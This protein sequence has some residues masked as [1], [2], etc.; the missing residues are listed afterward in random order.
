MGVIAGESPVPETYFGP[1]E[2][3]PWWDPSRARNAVFLDRDLRGDEVLAAAGLDWTVSKRPQ[4]FGD[5]PGAMNMPRLDGVEPILLNPQ[6]SGRW[7]ANVRD[8]DNAFLGPVMPGFRVFQNDELRA[9]GDE[10]LG[11]GGAY[12]HT[13]GSL[14]DGKIVW[15]LA[16]FDKAIHVKGDGSPIEDYLALINGHDGRHGCTAAS[17]MTR[18]WCGNTCEQALKGSPDKITLRHTSG[19]DGRTEQIRRVLDLHVQHRENLE[20][21]LNSLADRPMTIDE[22]R[23]Y[24]VALIP[25]NPT[26]KNP[27]RTQAKR[28]LIADLFTNSPTLDGVPQT[29]YRA[30]QATVEAADQYMRYPDTKLAKAADRLATAVIEGPAYALKT[31]AV[32]LLATA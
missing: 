24:T 32:R 28:D 27:I 16:K 15:L 7:M 2:R 8:T 30:Y 23:A 10:L 17:T 5:D 22:V 1:A 13:G 29:A 6:R 12:Y 20:T 18:I 9:L 3:M 21:F 14:Y 4:F 26:V 11:R 25:E 31:A 19:M